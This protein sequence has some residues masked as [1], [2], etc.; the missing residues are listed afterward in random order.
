MNDLGID[1]PRLVLLVKD[2]NKITG[3][4]NSDSFWDK[5]KSYCGLDENLVLD[6]LGRP[7][8]PDEWLKSSGKDCKSLKETDYLNF[9]ET[10]L[11][12]YKTMKKMRPGLTNSILI[13][14]FCKLL[15]T[16][17]AT[18]NSEEFIRFFQ[19]SVH[20][21]VLSL[22]TPIKIEFVDKFN[23]K[24]YKL[25]DDDIDRTEEEFK[26]E[27]DNL[28][29]QFLKDFLEKIDSLVY[30]TK[31]CDVL[32]CIKAETRVAMKSFS[33]ENHFLQKKNFA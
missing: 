6:I 29:L 1:I 4:S 7:P 31:E 19:G 24:A 12:K 27:L 21:V 33:A 22:V 14:D 30:L 15:D 13:E 32:E 23:E 8:P 25:A 11:H 18:I 9:N 20:Q 10:L 3:K 17:G 26:K 2:C 28:R 16:V 5:I